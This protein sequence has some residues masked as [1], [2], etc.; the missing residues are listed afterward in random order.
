MRNTIV[1][2][3]VLLLLTACQNDPDPTGI[4]LVPGGDVVSA[5]RFD[6]Q[7]DSSELRA[8]VY[9]FRNS[10]AGSTVLSVGD[11][12]DVR[13][14][15]LLRWLYFNIDSSLA[16]GGRIVSA[17]LRLHSLPYHV[18]DVSAPFS[19]ELREITGFWNAFTITADSLRDGRP[20]TAGVVGSY[21]GT[22]GETD[23]IDIAIDTALVRKWMR[24]SIEVNYTAN[25]G[26][27][28]QPPAGWSG[29]IRA[30]ASLDRSN[31]FPP[32]LTVIVEGANGRDTLTAESAD[33]TTLIDG[34][35]R[36]DAGRIVL[37][38]GISVRGKLYFDL[39]AIPAA[40]IV[41]HA[42][43]YLSWDETLSTDNYRGADSV[44]V[45][46]SVD[47]VAN[48]LNSTGVITRTDADMP[49]VLIAEGT[50]L[51]RAVQHWVNRKGNYGF[52][53]VPMYEIPDIDRLAL[54]GADAPPEKRP[55][56]VVTYTTK[57][58]LP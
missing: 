45:Y 42:T 3:A 34:P 28:L 16:Y 20:A 57:P 11:A 41:N 35:M 52:V 17:T 10:H 46:E 21:Q 27:M 36:S 8:D 29:S 14:A 43:L 58:D 56:L 12:D 37:Q 13:A 49:G 2:S 50:P 24:N 31:E 5:Q 25:L 40:S 33:N 47:S 39:D 55:R 51:T 53:L 38:S 9:V 48:T 19:M 1:L 54:Y 22:F 44:L 7:T 30:F 23:S 26:V 4:G 15:S 18:G 6:S 32:A